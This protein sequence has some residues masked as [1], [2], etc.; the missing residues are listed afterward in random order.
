M[1]LEIN[2]FDV[3]CLSEHW[4]RNVE[5]LLCY[6]IVNYKLISSFCRSKHVHGGVCIYVRPGLGCKR[7]NV[8]AFL[9]EVAAEF[10]AIEVI[11]E[12]ILIICI[13]RS[14]LADVQV[15]Y[16]QFQLL[17]DNMFD[18]YN[19]IILLGDFNIRF[20]EPS[21]GLSEFHYILDSYS[22]SVTISQNTRV[23]L[24][25]ATCIDNILTNIN[26]NMYSTAVINPSISDHYGQSIT[27]NIP[28]QKP[29]IVE[30]R[31][32]TNK[33]IL[34]F[35]N[36]LSNLNW[37]NFY[38]SKDIDGLAEF[39]VTNIKCLIETN[40]PLK[41]VKNVNTDTLISWFTEDLK[42]MRNRVSAAKQIAD[43]SGNPSHKE[44]YKKLQTLYKEAIVNS[45]QVAYS[46]FITSSKNKAR[47]VWKIINS[48]RDSGSASSLDCTLTA[49]E[50]NTFFFPL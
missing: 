7:V 19:K 38:F 34:N 16:K 40:Y 37:D 28:T 20:N 22:L 44:A 43:F 21:N 14:C 25:S 46:N 3:V 39:L 31:K 36:S 17:I 47:D 26:K 18:R 15:F 1:F 6:N 13:Y 33:G 11:P 12:K 35:A 10:C 49:D 8:E 42:V 30:V 24:K 32:I 23:S 41:Q 29:K 27:I 48:E 5:T 2:D 4:E 9:Q 45:K 50:F